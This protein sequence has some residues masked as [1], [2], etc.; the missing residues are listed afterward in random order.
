[1]DVIQVKIVNVYTCGMYDIAQ[2]S[3]EMTQH[4]ADKV[5]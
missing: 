3:E 5:Y 4:S 2:S 1:M